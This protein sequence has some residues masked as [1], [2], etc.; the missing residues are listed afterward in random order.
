MI[1][2]HRETTESVMGKQTS[3][4]L[5]AYLASDAFYYFVKERLIDVASTVPVYPLSPY[6]KHKQE[7]AAMSQYDI[8]HNIKNAVGEIG[9]GVNLLFVS[10]LKGYR[11]ILSINGENGID[12]PIFVMPKYIDKEARD[13]YTQR[14][15]ELNNT[16]IFVINPGI[17]IAYII[18]FYAMLFHL[19]VRYGLAKL[20]SGIVRPE[21]EELIIV[22]LLLL[23]L[24]V[25][26]VHLGRFTIAKFYLKASYKF[27]DY[28]LFMA[29]D[30][31]KKADTDEK[32]I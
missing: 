5:Y 30:N 22:I 8:F 25:I 7:L 18:C 9:E 24:P 15:Q 31:N 20:E 16:K 14:V 27:T 32:E 26:G 21:W 19:S 17:I 2:S 10:A 29:Y 23:C 11:I 28:S 6:K 3:D 4:K 1:R 12:I 13:I